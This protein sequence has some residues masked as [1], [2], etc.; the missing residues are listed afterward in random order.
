MNITNG[1]GDDVLQA[2][3]RGPYMLV[4]LR[5]G[6]YTVHARYKDKEQTKSVNI[7]GKGHANAAF[8]WN[9]Q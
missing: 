1:H 3:S 5:P 6:H 9:E 7:G 4:R 8:Y 2:D